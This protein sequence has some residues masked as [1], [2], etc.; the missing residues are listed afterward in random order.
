[1]VQ[2]TETKDSEEY[3]YSGD[4]Y[5]NEFPVK[6][7]NIFQTMVG[8]LS[9]QK[10]LL[11]TIGFI[12]IIYVVFKIINSIEHRDKNNQQTV[13]KT[14]AT[15]LQ[16]TTATPAQEQQVHERINN[17]QTEHAG[18]NEKLQE[19]QTNVANINKKMYNV[20]EAVAN[21]EATVG[22]LQN[23]IQ[24]VI[25]AERAARQMRMNRLQHHPA[26]LYHV[27][28]IIPNRAWLRDAKG[29]TITV[30]PGSYLPRMGSVVAIDSAAGTVTMENGVKIGFALYDR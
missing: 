11:V 18:Q 4:A 3:S 6:K 25:I 16:D 27:Y 22:R 19:L 29:N 21:L 14:Q 1:M 17:L 7:T 10:G 26:A 9:K 20:Q 13:T 5:S 23:I 30:R 24:Q 15:K 8:K 28:A 2:E 12:V